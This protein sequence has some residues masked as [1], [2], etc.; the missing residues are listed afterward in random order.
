MRLSYK[1]IGKDG[2]PVTGLV[3]AKDIN[4]AAVYLRTRELLPIT[5]TKKEKSKLLEAIPL[6]KR[7]RTEDLVFF[8]RQLSSML[9]SGLTLIRALEILKQQMRGI[10]MLEVLDAVI[11]DIEGG[12]SFSSAIAKHPDMFSP[13]Y[14]SIIKT[15]EESGLLDKALLRLADNLEKQA[16]LRSSIKGALMYPVIVVTLMIAVVV[17]MM[18]FVIPQL[19]ILYENLNIPLPLPTQIII[20]MSKFIIVFWPLVIGF[21][22]LASVLY[23][24]FAKSPSGRLIIDDT[25]LKFPVFGKLIIQTILAEF[26]RT[27]GLLVGTGTLVVDALLQTASTSGNIHYKNAIIDVSKKVEKGVTI[28]DAMS[29]SPLFPPLLVQLVRIGEQTGKLDDSLLKAS[30]YFE[31]EVDQQVKTLTTAM[32]PIIMIVLGVGVALLIASVITPIYNLISS[33]Q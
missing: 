23:R 12:S 18:I 14:A 8:T 27:F 16:K 19:S 26:A 30:E 7:S 24:R 21:I 17:I 10:Y 20:G 13:I 4:E 5:I 25:V 9:T 6:L 31:S 11:T 29:Y 22:V 3:E 28:G 1:A 33:I 32:E 2:K 15:A